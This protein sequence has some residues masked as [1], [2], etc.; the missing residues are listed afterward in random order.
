MFT[1][2]SLCN[3][4]INPENIR[5]FCI[6]AHVDHGKTT[7]SDYLLC[8]NGVMSEMLA[9]NVLYLDNRP[10]EQ[11][12]MITMKMSCVAL[13][14]TLTNS[15]KYLCNLIDS[16]GHIDFSCEVSTAIRVSDGAIIIVDI[17]DG[18]SMQTHA[19]I[20]QALMEGL[21]MLLI[22]NKIDIAIHVQSISPTEF[23]QRVSN[24]VTSC[25]SII[26]SYSNGKTGFNYSNSSLYEEDHLNFA[27]T[28]LMFPEKVMFS[29]DKNNVL[30]ASCL[31]GWGFSLADFANL[32]SNRMSL[33]K[34]ATM[35][36]LWGEHYVVGR[37]VISDPSDPRIKPNAMPLFVTHVAKVII[38]I[39][40]ACHDQLETV[41]W[42][43]VTMMANALNVPQ[44]AWNTSISRTNHQKLN[45]ILSTWAPLARNV[46]DL[47]CQIIDSPA[48]CNRR[49]LPGLIPQLH[50]TPKHIRDA[51]W[52]SSV[53]NAPTVAHV[54]KL[55]DRQFITGGDILQNKEGSMPLETLNDTFV[56]FGRIYCGVIKKGDKLYV[57]NDTV[58]GCITVESLF[59]LEGT[60]LVT[61]DQLPAGYLFAASGFADRVNKTATL[62][63]EPGLPPF[64]SLKL[65]SSSILHY[66]INSRNPSDMVAL[67]HAVGLLYKVDP[68]LQLAVLPTGDYMICCAGEI[69]AERIAI[70]LKERFCP[71]VEFTF[72][73]PVITVRETIVSSTMN[74][75]IVTGTTPDGGFNIEL[76]ALPL[77][78]ETLQLIQPHAPSDQLTQRITHSLSESSEKWKFILRN[79]V[80]DTA[81]KK[82]SLVGAFL[83][84]N[85]RANQNPGDTE[86]QCEYNSLSSDPLMEYVDPGPMVLLTKEHHHYKEYSNAIVAGFELASQAGPMVEEPMFGVI[87]VITEVKVTSRAHPGT[88]VNREFQPK[89]A[90]N[91]APS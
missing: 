13:E 56:A 86:P 66:T 7:L 64:K 25:N 60:G 77:P 76:Y 52:R 37:E 38:S 51:L 78:S 84:D 41:D 68:Q 33:S 54:V 88:K 34:E 14:Y 28:D 27:S 46:L 26:S 83:V 85:S 91:S 20:R 17:I 42:D 75:Q 87:F 50:K 35:K 12:R 40:Q 67:L 63:S 45:K 21:Q 4:N 71:G 11:E 32:Y 62:C 1:S 55:I 22:I 39:H 9:G 59:I 69:H 81:P 70:D 65:M 82:F 89:A 8:H 61:V 3:R 23:Y 6:L 10:D 74:P 79:G 15:S 5:N 73:V 72:S 29:P 80:W 44:K 58:Q 90:D 47:V 53:L 19:L 2:E 30:F 18:V 43:R 48:Q 16:P 49:R 31:N 36:A 24:I 57:S